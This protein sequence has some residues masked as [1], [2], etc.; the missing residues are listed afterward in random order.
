MVFERVEY[1]HISIDWASWLEALSVH[2]CCCCP[3]WPIYRWSC[4]ISWHVVSELL[5]YPAWITSILVL[6][7]GT[8]GTGSV[9]VLFQPPWVSATHFLWLSCDC[10]NGFLQWPYRASFFSPSSEADIQGGSP[11]SRQP[12]CFSIPLVGLDISGAVLMCLKQNNKVVS[13]VRRLER[14]GQ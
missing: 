10:M 8:A 5:S 13:K 14:Q 12:K 4:W 9:L 11:G 1:L 7:G 6:C 2:H 3:R